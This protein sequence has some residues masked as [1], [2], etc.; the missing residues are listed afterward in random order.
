[1][2]FDTSK[3]MRWHFNKAADA[4]WYTGSCESLM[5]LVEKGL[6]RLIGESVLIFIPYT[7]KLWNS[8]PLSVFPPG[9]DFNFLKEEC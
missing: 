7:G 2:R 4:P 1:M 3:G 8:L 9:Y 5:R 6:T